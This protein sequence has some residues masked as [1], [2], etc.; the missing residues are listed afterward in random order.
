MVLPGLYI[1]FRKVVV[2]EF[3]SNLNGGWGTLS[4]PCPEQ[5]WLSGGIRR[6]IVVL[7]HF[8]AKPLQITQDDDVRTGFGYGNR[9]VNISFWSGS[10]LPHLTL[11]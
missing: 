4:F 9:D 1:L 5:T 3:V 10:H 6:D 2:G 7:N 8:I 11:Y